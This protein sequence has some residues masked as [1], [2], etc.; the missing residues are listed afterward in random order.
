MERIYD[1][2]ESCKPRIRHTSGLGIILIIAGVIFLVS[3]LGFI[4]PVVKSIVI[5]WQSLLIVLGLINLSKRQ[6]VWSTV[7]IMVGAFFMIPKLIYL[8]P[9]YFPRMDPDFARLYW[10][11]L[12]IAMGIAVLF[13]RN[14]RVCCNVHR[15]APPI[16]PV[17]GSSHRTR[18]YSGRESGCYEKNAVFG[19]TELI[20]LDPEFTGGEFNSVFGHIKI[21]LRNT[22]IP[23]GDTVIETNSVFGGITLYVPAD[24]VIVTKFSTVFGGFYDK[25]P[26]APAKDPERRLI[27][28]GACVFGGGEIIS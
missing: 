26:Q 28:E 8:F 27:I 3:N 2:K 21:D 9:W 5:S 11:F 14:N 17:Y 15:E 24:W 19:E 20:I 16:P 13:V 12:L 10:P 7:L 22:T 23:E 4:D 1:E 25:R 18:H 6:Y